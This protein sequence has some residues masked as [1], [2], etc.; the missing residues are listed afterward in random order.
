M[1]GIMS[2]SPCEA[3]YVAASA[4][5]CN[6]PCSAPAA[7]PSDCISTTRTGEPNRFLLPCVD[8]KSVNSA[9]GEEGVMGKM[10]ATSV[11][12]YEIRA[13]AV[14]PSIVCVLRVHIRAS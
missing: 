14:L 9:M 1:L 2:S 6:A 13:A 4:P 10:A 3:V 5:P 12:G 11:K 8:H 7:P